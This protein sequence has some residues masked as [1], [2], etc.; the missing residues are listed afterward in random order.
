LCVNFD[1]ILV[2]VHDIPTS[3][4]TV[5]GYVC[6]TN[7]VD[8]NYTGSG[9]ED[10][11]FTWYFDGGDSTATEPGY[12]VS[13]DE[14]GVKTLW[15]VVEENECVSDTSWHS[16]S[17]N[18]SPTSEFEASG[19]VCGP[20]AL[21]VTYTGTGSPAADYNW[22][23]EMAA[24]IA[25]SGQGPYEIT[26][27][28]EGTHEIS[29]NVVENNCSSDINVKEIM[30]DFPY[31]GLEI[32]L[33][34]IDVETGYNM[35]IWERPADGGIASFNVYRET[36]VQGQYE[37]LENVPYDD[38]SIY[39]DIAS[40]PE[41]KSHKYK[42]AV[43]DTCGNES[44][45][46]AYH[47]TMLLTS[48]LG[49]DRINLSWQEYEVEG[50]GFGF[51]KYLIYR[52]DTPG[53]LEVLDSIASDNVLYPDIDPPSDTMFYRIAGVKSS[54][55]AP[56]KIGGVKAGA[57]PYSHS[58]SNLEDNRLQTSGLNDLIREKYQ[59]KVYP[60]PFSE[61][62]QLSYNLTGVSDVKIEVYNLLGA[63]ILEMVTELQSPGDYRYDLSA[64]DIGSTEGIFYIRFTVDDKSMV[65][66]VIL[67]R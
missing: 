30:V 50:G 1:N 27:D 57:G 14:T 25:G 46:S 32:C 40:E 33:V 9:T 5:P 11:I 19:S 48:N 43:V 17:V 18:S 41:K 24:S 10:A 29:L 55:C 58:I 6:D 36:S 4:F 60:N 53:T 64:A 28:T 35:V 39:V 38:L 66:K 8:V 61:V 52:G 7:E 51:V 13:W 59:F 20:E 65:K 42:I 12:L 15:L 62:T 23:F 56:A 34:T 31:A 3:Y 63:R 21:D 54:E 16:I 26:W 2:T 49:S 44:S 22:N 37:I 67:A 47:K 45:L